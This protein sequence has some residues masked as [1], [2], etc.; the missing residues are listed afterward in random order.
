[1]GNVLISGFKSDQSAY[2]SEIGGICTLVM[3]VELIKSMWILG[4]GSVIIGCDG[5]NALYKAFDYEYMITLCHQRPF[6]F[7]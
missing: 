3:V 5:I 7:L 1:M 6:D 4:N 2:R